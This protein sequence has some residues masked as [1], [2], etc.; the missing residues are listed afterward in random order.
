VE[1]KELVV[2]DACDCTRDPKCTHPRPW[3]G[4]DLAVS[5]TSR[6]QHTNYVPS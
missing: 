6:N 1:A 4:P 3:W 5:S 2:E